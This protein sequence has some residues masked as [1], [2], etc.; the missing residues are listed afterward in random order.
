MRSFSHSVP[1]GQRGV[2]RRKVASRPSDAVSGRSSVS[3]VSHC[4]H[5]ATSRRL[6]SPPALA[7]RCLSSSVPTKPVTAPAGLTDSWVQAKPRAISTSSAWLARAGC[8]GGGGAGR[9]A[10]SVTTAGAGCGAGGCGAGGCGRSVAGGGVT[11]A[12]GVAGAPSTVK[13]ECVAA[14]K[15]R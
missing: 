2:G 4:G 12:T 7:R 5:G 10:G 14:A 15:A 8:A 3:R 11:A 9:G 1:F 6:T 13:A